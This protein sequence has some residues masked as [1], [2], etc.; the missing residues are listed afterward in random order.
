M[1]CYGLL[2]LGTGNT[3]STHVVGS[4]S[5]DVHSHGRPLTFR[6]MSGPALALVVQSSPR[7]AL[8]IWDVKRES[9]VEESTSSDSASYSWAKAVAADFTTWDILLCTRKSY[10]ELWDMRK[11]HDPVAISAPNVGGTKTLRADFP[12]KRALSSS[13]DGVVHVATWIRTH[14][15]TQ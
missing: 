12:A 3:H 4:A 10:L 9:C 7:P 13:A 14:H 8:K 5:W 15:C 6:R 1:A 2:R 11:L